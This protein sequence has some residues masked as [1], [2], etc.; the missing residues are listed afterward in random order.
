[1]V[2]GSL[3]LS[4]SECFSPFLHSTG[5]LSV[6]WEC[7]ALP[8]GPGGFAQDSS[9]PALLRIPLGPSS[10]RIQACHLLWGFF[11]EASAH[12]SDTNSSLSKSSRTSRL[13]GYSGF[14]GNTHIKKS[15]RIII[16]KLSVFE[17]RRLPTLPHCIAVPSAQAGL[18]SLF[19]MGRGGT[20]P[21]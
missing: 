3:S 13:S 4:L 12:D 11:P 9:C 15:L 16:L 20:L 8:D 10:L 18:T 7:L 14:S 17:R 2:S 5:S 21:Q 1:M 6:S 19:G